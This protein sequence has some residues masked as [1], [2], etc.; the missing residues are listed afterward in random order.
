MIRHSQSFATIQV[1]L[2]ALRPANPR[3]RGLPPIPGGTTSMSPRFRDA[4]E[5]APP[6]PIDSHV[7]SNDF[8]SLVRRQLNLSRVD[9]R[10]TA[11]GIR[12]AGIRPSALARTRLSRAP[13]PPL[14]GP[15]PSPRRT[16]CRA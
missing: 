10:D 16:L 4:V 14:A 7:S 12:E 3:A 15:S 11:R 1:A 5:R 9:Q 13:A 2:V 8:A 6:T